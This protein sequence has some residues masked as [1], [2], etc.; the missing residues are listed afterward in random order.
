[1]DLVGKINE[2]DFAWPNSSTVCVQARGGH[3]VYSATLTEVLI[4]GKFEY[5]HS[6]LDMVIREFELMF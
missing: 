4:A 6:I 5:A 1:M 3:L 2:H